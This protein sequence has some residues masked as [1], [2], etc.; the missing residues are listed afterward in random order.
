MPGVKVG[1]AFTCQMAGNTVCDRI[2]QVT[3]RSS[4]MGFQSI[5]SY[6][7]LYLVTFMV[8]DS[9]SPLV[10]VAWKLPCPDRLWFPAGMG[11]AGAHVASLQIEGDCPG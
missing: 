7:H 4:V 11:A 9:G 1:R 3:L 8:R 5:K 10:W 2:W 6:T